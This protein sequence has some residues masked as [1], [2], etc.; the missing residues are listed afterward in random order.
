MYS[1]KLKTAGPDVVVGRAWYS[2]HAK[3]G[4]Q[5]IQS[6]IDNNLESSLMIGDVDNWHAAAHKI[7]TC[8]AF[9]TDRDF[10]F[11]TI[12]NPW[13]RHVSNYVYQREKVLV[14]L[15]YINDGLASDYIKDYPNQQMP[16]DRL[17]RYTKALEH[18]RDK[19]FSTFESYINAVEFCSMPLR[20]TNDTDYKSL[21]AFTLEGTNMT[22]SMSSFYNGGDLAKVYLLDIS[23]H[24][25][26]LNFFNTNFGIAITQVPYV[27]VNPTGYHYREYYNDKTRRQIEVIESNVIEI[28]KY[29]Y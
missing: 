23:N 10:I 15:R 20:C 22:Q 13:E 12:R 4:S 27:N 8:A 5:A 9:N 1:I 6:I 19:F 28:G 17:S 24:D 18:Y 29:K 25:S 3:T 21:K 26:I 11:G 7:A 14:K 2:P 16:L